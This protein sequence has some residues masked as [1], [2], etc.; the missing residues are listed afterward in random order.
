MRALVLIL[1]LST[2]AWAGWRAE[3][4]HT[5]RICRQSKGASLTCP[6]L[7]GDCHIVCGPDCEPTTTLP[8]PPS[9]VTLTCAG[10][11]VSC[12]IVHSSTAGPDVTYCSVPDLVDRC[13]LPPLSAVQ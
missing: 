1:A 13:G 2:P 6:Q 12:V 9:G 7:V 8:P 5:N 11:P 4:R 3:C 10:Q